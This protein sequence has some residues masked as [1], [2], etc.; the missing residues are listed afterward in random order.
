MILLWGLLS[1]MAVVGG[2]VGVVAG[3]AGTPAPRRAPWWQR[4]L[5]RRGPEQTD[6][7]RMRRRA[8]S[9]VAS[10]VFAGVWL[11]SGNFV[12]GVLLG[13]AVIGVPW[14]VTPGQIA[15]ERIGRLE[16]LSEW[17]GR[18]AGLLRLGM[19]LEQAMIASRQGAPDEL[20]AQI[21]NLADR[22]RLGW[23]PEEA[24]RAFGDELGDV[25]GDKVVAALILSAGDRGPGL[26]QALE[27]LAGSVR[28]EVAKKRSIE[29]DRAK[30]RTT[31]RWMTIITVG[32]VVAGFFVPSYTAPYS[33]LLGQLVLAF[34]T[35]GFVATLVLMRQ[36][37]AFRR[38]PRFL[39]PDAASTVRLPTPAAVAADAPAVEREHEGAHS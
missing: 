2:L 14:L 39:I 8:L 31:V 23:R 36:L 28:D 29:A 34:L 16:A 7:V 4:M 11:V 1:G 24:L 17:T 9:V 33:T 27:D 37:G 25:T 35:V 20:A 3:I 10:G 6:G 5:A 21:V 15:A 22:L 30:P 38:I 12:A 32:I 19:G 13:A 26:A 18:L